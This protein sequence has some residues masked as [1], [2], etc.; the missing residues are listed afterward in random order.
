MPNRE[1]NMNFLK[2]LLLSAVISGIMIG[3]AGYPS[4]ERTISAD[5]V[6]D[7]EVPDELKKVISVHKFEDRS[8]N[9]TQYNPW[10]MG[11]PDMV[12]QSLSAM[13]YFKVI[14]REYIQQQVIEE[15]QFQLLGLTDDAAA[16]EIGRLLNADYI[17]SGAFSVYEEIL[18]VNARCISVETGEIVS[19]VQS[20]GELRSF[21]ILQNQVAVEIAEN[22]NLYVSDEAR[23]NL[24]QRA[25]T[26]VIEASL[27]NYQGEEKLETLALLESQGQRQKI[28]EMKEAARED[29][30]RALS[31][32]SDYEKAKRNLSKLAL[33]IPM[34]L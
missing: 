11:I 32:D 3:C 20:S 31:F 24:N 6:M 28:E 17:V 10:K 4:S 19:Q 1:V 21:Y 2:Y 7:V 34:T 26:R 25:D 22:M 8:I 12:M 27:S 18:Q 5:P 16:V 30:E 23:T 14:S 15:Q 33:S 9:T 29:F 13:P